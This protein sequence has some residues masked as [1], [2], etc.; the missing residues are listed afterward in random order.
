MW[1]RIGNR[2]KYLVLS[3]NNSIM[4]TWLPIASGILA[5]FFWGVSFVAIKIALPQ[6]TLETM[7]FFRQFLGTL[8]VAIIVG[9]RGEWQLGL[10]DCIC[11]KQSNGR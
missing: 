9:L 11:R 1:G 3:N 7:I 5:V 4:I 8:T 2:C 6:M 10:E